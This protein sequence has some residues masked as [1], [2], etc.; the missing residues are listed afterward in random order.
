M[1][2]NNKKNGFSLVELLVAITV[3]SLVMSIAAGLFVHVFESQTQA[4]SYQELFDQT[5]FIMEYLARGVRMAKKQRT[6]TDPM[7]PAC[8][9]VGRNYELVSQSHLRF[10]RRDGT[11]TPPAFICYEFRLSGTRLEVSR[12]RGSSWSALTSPRLEVVTLRFRVVGDGIETP[13]LQ[14]MVTIVLEVR[15]RG[16]GHGRRSTIHLQTTISQRDFDI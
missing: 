13:P 6:A 7:N 5:S 3:F 10:I 9:S 4:L 12:D 14:P 2:K 1:K 15:G 16:Y 11:L 8:I